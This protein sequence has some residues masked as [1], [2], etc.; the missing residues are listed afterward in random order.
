MPGAR[1]WLDHP[2]VEDRVRAIDAVAP[3]AIG[4]TLLDPEQWSALKRICAGS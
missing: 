1:I 2:H 3:P 4:T